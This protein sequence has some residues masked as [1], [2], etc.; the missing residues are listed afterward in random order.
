M[1]QRESLGRRVLK[2]ANIDFHC[3]AADVVEL[4]C[5][6]PARTGGKSRIVSAV[7]LFNRLLD[8][9]PDLAP[10]LFAPF[11]LDRRGENRSGPSLCSQ[12][13]PCWFAE[14]EMQFLSNHTI[15]RART[16]YNDDPERPRHLLRLWLS[17]SHP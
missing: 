16:V 11:K 1:R 17:L 14:G 9:Q 15:A 6:Q 7:T 10:R 12:L 3:D 4:P 2:P 8:C 13:P 5:P